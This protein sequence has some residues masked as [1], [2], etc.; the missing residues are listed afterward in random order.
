MHYSTSRICKRLCL[1]PSSPPV[2]GGWF[3]AALGRGD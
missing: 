1:P 3:G 2:A